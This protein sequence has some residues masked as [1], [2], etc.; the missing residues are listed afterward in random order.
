MTQALDVTA[1]AGVATLT[2]P[3][4]PLVGD[5]VSAAVWG[6]PP[7]DPAQPPFNVPKQAST[8]NGS[9]IGVL[10]GINNVFTLTTGLLVT[11]I[12]LF[13]NGVMMT[14]NVD[15]TWVCLQATSA[16]PWVTTITMMGGQNPA[17]DSVL[18]A[19]IFNQ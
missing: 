3:Q 12:V 18:T 19:Q 7:V 17:A 2:S 16:G 13:F 14:P 10:N 6:V 11:G 8:S 5:I 15:F 9:I 1:S 4:T